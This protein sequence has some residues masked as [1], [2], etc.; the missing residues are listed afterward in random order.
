MKC[1]ETLGTPHQQDYERAALLVSGV[2]PAKAGIQSLL[3]YLDSRLRGSDER[4]VFFSNLLETK[5]AGGVAPPAL[6]TECFS[7]AVNRP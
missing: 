4:I 1:K 2:I 5:K 6:L 7:A 3:A